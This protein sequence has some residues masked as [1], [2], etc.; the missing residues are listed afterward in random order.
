MARSI[1]GLSPRAMT[2]SK[3]PMRFA[4]ALV[5]LLSLPVF[6]PGCASHSKTVPLLSA[7]GIPV[8]MTPTSAVPLEVVTRSTAIDDPLPVTGSDTFYADVES[9]LGHAI[10]SAT[11]PWADA[12]RQQRPEG[13]QILVEITRASA[14]YSAGRLM[15]TFDVRATLRTRIGNAYLA[16]TQAHC[17]QAGLVAPSDGAPVVYSCMTGLGRDLGGW[18]GSVEP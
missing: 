8:T 13:W 4:A 7:A 5:A 17:M 14:D 6:A 12:H 9:A 15:V 10:A 3:H 18:L 2:R 16:Q 11:V 1:V